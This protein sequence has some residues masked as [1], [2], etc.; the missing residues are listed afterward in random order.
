[1]Q[2]KNSQVHILNM[3]MTELLYEVQSYSSSDYGK[4]N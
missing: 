2:I 1:M 3:G 4:G